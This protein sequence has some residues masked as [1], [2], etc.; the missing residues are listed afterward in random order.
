MGNTVGIF[1]SSIFRCLGSGLPS[2][3]LLL[4]PS[5]P[6]LLLPFPSSA[7]LSLLGLWVSVPFLPHSFSSFSFPSPSF[8]RISG[9]GV[10]F[11]L[12]HFHSFLGA[13]PP[14]TTGPRRQAQAAGTV[15]PGC[16]HPPQN[17]AHADAASPDPARGHR[18]LRLRMR[19]CF[20]PGAVGLERNPGQEGSSRI[21]SPG[22]RPPG[23]QCNLHIRTVGR[24]CP[25]P[26]AQL[27]QATHVGGEHIGHLQGR[28]GPF[29]GGCHQLGGQQQPHP[30]PEVSATFGRPWVLWKG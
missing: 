7:I 12:S 26:L 27:A 30:R 1:P 28:R 25:G 24:G 3:L 10:L 23:G 8:L 9:P 21:S 19:G 16:S 22:V 17:P 13:S 20:S 4:F 29:L 2:P 14:C 11:T 18:E 15:E 6:L 5:L